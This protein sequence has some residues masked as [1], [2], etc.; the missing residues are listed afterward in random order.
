MRDQPFPYLNASYEDI[1]KIDL[2]KHL[3]SS[4]TDS[5]GRIVAVFDNVISKD[6]VDTIRDYFLSSNAAYLYDGY[7]NKYDEDNDN[8][9]WIVK[10]DVSRICIVL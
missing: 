5:T 3:T 2:S 8:V 6:E 7:D 1:Y 9:N 4:F 10:K